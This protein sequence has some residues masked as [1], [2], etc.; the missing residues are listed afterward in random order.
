MKTAGLRA[1]TNTKVPSNHS[2]SS[3][4]LNDV[5]SLDVVCIH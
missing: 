5:Y 2:F 1:M 4:L 3:L